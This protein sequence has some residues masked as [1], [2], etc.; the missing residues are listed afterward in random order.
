MGRG[1]QL[2]IKRKISSVKSTMHMTRAMEM[3]ATARLQFLRK[4]LKNFYEYERTLSSVFERV[5]GSI[6]DLDEVKDLI[7]KEPSKVM[8]VVITGDMGLC[9]TYNDEVIQKAYERE[10]SLGKKFDS[11][12]VIGSKAFRRMK[13]DGKRIKR[14][15]LESYSR[16]FYDDAQSL[17]NELLRIYQKGEVDCVEIIHGYPKNSLIQEVK[18]EIFIPIK[19]EKKDHEK[20]Y[21]FEPRPEEIFRML[22]PQYF[23]SKIYRILLESRISEQNAR[24]N[25]MRNA[26]ENAKKLIDDLTLQYNKIRQFYITQEVIEITN[27][28]EVLKGEN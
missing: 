20:F 2:E 17:S 7:W 15:V 3:V 5:T 10:I 18:D 1:M 22:V 4:N 14:S 24:Q 25:A 6:E 12:Y 27:S 21:D 26:T 19:I 13:Y 23:G 9:G 8:L 16:P 11:F 28:A